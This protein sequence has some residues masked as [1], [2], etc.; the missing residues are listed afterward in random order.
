MLDNLK[1]PAGALS[2]QQLQ[3]LD[4]GAWA[5]AGSVEVLGVGEVKVAVEKLDMLLPILSQVLDA[6]IRPAVR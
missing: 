3:Q 2:E 6:P 4:E 1:L 5:K